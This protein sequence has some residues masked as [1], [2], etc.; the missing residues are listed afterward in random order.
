MLNRV[1]G[2]VV[3]YVD[4]A[5]Y[6]GDVAPLF[7]IYEQQVISYRQKQ[8]LSNWVIGFVLCSLSLLSL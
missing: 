6:L 4:F 7:P 3:D 2:D 1:F 8:S 5:L